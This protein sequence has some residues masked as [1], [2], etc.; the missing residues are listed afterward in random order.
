M[1]VGTAARRYVCSHRHQA[2]DKVGSHRRQAVDEVGSHA[3]QAVDEASCVTAVGSSSLGPQPIA[4]EPGLA[5]SA[6]RGSHPAG[7]PGLAPFG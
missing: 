2:V 5:P 1:L 7:E 6:N 3:A 4:G